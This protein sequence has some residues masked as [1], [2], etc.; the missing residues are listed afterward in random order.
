[1]LRRLWRRYTNPYHRRLL[2]IIAGIEAYLYLLF[3][4]YHPC[5][6]CAQFREIHNTRG[7]VEWV[8]RVLTYPPLGVFL[9]MVILFG[10]LAFFW[11]FF[12]A[13]FILPVQG[14][15]KRKGIFM[16]LLYY[17]VGMHGPA[18]F[19][20]DGQVIENKGERFRKGPGVIVLDLAS[21]AVL[22]NEANFTRAV[23]PGVI[24]TAAGETIPQGAAIDLRKR[25]KN[26]GPYPDEDP[27]APQGPD[28]KAEAYRQ[29][30]QRRW[31]TS[32]I[33][34]DGT[35]VVARLL[36]V[37]ALDKHPDGISEEIYQRQKFRTDFNG[38]GV[39]AWRAIAHRPI[40]VKGTASKEEDSNA[41]NERR[42]LPWD[43][44][45]PR[46]AADLWREYLQLFKL[47]DLFREVRDGQS[48]LDIIN[49]AVQERLTSPTYTEMV[50]DGRLTG[51][52]LPS[53]EYA[54]LQARGIR[55]I[56]FL[57]TGIFLPPA[58]EEGLIARWVA[59]WKARAEKERVLV[60][61]KRLL[62]KKY[63]EA[64]AAEMWGKLIAEDACQKAVD[65]G[66]SMA[67]CLE[68]LLYVLTRAVQAD[69][70]LY[71]AQQPDVDRL[72]MLWAWAH[73]FAIEQKP[74][75]EEQ[76]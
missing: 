57:V 54:L 32:G 46:L 38:H 21:A 24:F 55:V 74:P 15:N 70:S 44:L 48:A 69:P 23:G 42:L 16:R 13:Q 67:Q 37:F 27:F 36:V 64:A 71:Q 19:V 20:Q 65:E 49:A 73:D 52:T 34:Q 58:V 72:K 39:S 30:Q 45:P 35:E 61:Q 1:M 40:E 12:F 22:K 18:L 7:L 8:S 53:R 60:E 2:L 31:E 10:A 29:R 26:L 68:R 56:T 3:Q 59:D 25:S 11:L 14:W 75:P 17:A 41:Q 63:G 5:A 50:R 47:S 51:Q 76:P 6:I 43:W 28:E 66:L 4:R 33:T 62:A 9:G